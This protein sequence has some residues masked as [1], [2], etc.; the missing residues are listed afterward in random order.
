MKGGCWRT[1]RETGGADARTL[2]ERQ[3]TFAATDLKSMTGDAE[4]RELVVSRRRP[5]VYEA[6]S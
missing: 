1:L 3:P 4:W 2:I 5:C 6:R